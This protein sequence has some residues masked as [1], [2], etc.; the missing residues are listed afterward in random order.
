VFFI[1]G[2]PVRLILALVASLL[3]AG[4]ARAA[5]TSV[6]WTAPIK[7]TDGSA[8]TDLA[9][10]KIYF[11]TA[12]G[13]LT[14]VVTIPNAGVSTYVVDNLTPGSWYFAVTAY[15]ASGMESAR[16]NVATRDLPSITTPQPPTSVTLTARA[17]YVI[18]Q[19][20]D[21]LA[22]IPVG[23]VPAATACDATRGVIAAGQ[24]YYRVP[25]SAVT[26][27]GSVRSVVV[28]ADCS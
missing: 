8:L 12:P 19:T 27:A 26:W 28:F 11:G 2:G 13:A 10:F 5:S 20:Q 21:N 25:V 9:G 18:K 17:V 23:S 7:N 22:V 24:A 4:A 14:N 3:F 1:P 16:S 15:T 6:S